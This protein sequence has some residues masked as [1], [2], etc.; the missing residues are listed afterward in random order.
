MANSK[1]TVILADDHN[2]V[3]NGIAGLLENTPGIYI[4]GEASNGRELVNK[5]SECMPDVVITD[6]T[7]PVF[8]GIV[9]AEKIKAK[10]RKAKIL[11]LSVSDSEEYIY[12]ALK[13]GALGLINKSVTKG[14]LVLAIETVSHGQKYFGKTYNQA[15][16]NEIFQKYNQNKN[17]SKHYKMDLTSREIDTLRGICEGKQS[18]EIAEELGVSKR[19]ID[20]HRSNLMKK[21]DVTSTSQ[22]IKYVYLNKIID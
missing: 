15:R 3:R 14:E 9:A 12:Q 10:N 8:S 21:F 2:L 7:M 4:I 20:G 18:I 16:L 22:L 13:V 6:I 17:I 1:I 5:Y 19:T 11:F